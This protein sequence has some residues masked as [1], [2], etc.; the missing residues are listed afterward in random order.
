MHY[1]AAHYY[2]PNKAVFQDFDPFWE[3]VSGPLHAG[4]WRPGASST[5]RSAR[6]PCIRMAAAAEQGESSTLLRTAI[7]R[8]RID[9][10][11]DRKS[12]T[13]TLKDV[14]DN[15]LWSVDIN[16]R[17]DKWSRRAPVARS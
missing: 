2:D 4:T 11:R 6:A 17:F 10:R 16:P 3:F 15:D 14:E 7:L 9:R 5:T 13:V 1:T 8:A 12:V